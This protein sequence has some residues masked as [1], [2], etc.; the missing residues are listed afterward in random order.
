[1]E[2]FTTVWNQGMALAVFGGIFAILALFYSLILPN[3]GMAKAIRGFVAANILT[4]GLVLSGAAMISSLV[5]SEIIGYAPCLLCWYSRIAFYP[6]VI[7]FGLA[8]GKKDYSALDYSLALTIAGTIISLYHVVTEA[9]QYSPLPCSAGGV[10]CLT[11]Y[12]Y[13]YGFVTIPVM[14]LVGFG[15]LLMALIVAKRANKT[16]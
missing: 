12:V 8:I 13:E 1:M 7:I 6:Q 14:G 3:D 10:S 4:I 9:I 5:Y 11:R 16:A 2:T 15:T